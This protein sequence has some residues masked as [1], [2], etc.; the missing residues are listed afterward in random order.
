MPFPPSLRFSDLNTLSATDLAKLADLQAASLDEAWSTESLTSMIQTQ[1][2]FGLGVFNDEACV[3]FSVYLPGVDD[4]ELLSIATAPALRGQGVAKH[5]L[6][7]GE[8]TA[9]A[10]GFDRILLEV[11]DDNLAARALYDRHGFSKDGIRKG[12]YARA[13]A[14]ARDAILMSKPIK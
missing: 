13:N 4:C 11:A 7:E 3:G 9:R 5:L 12:Y 6:D 8:R 1:S 2:A 10:A 14:P